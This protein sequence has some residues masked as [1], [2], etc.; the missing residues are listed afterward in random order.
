MASISFHDFIR[1]VLMAHDLQ[2]AVIGTLDR[3]RR[4]SDRRLQTLEFA[5]TSRQLACI[6]LTGQEVAL[7]K[8]LVVISIGVGTISMGFSDLGHSIDQ[9][10]HLAST[11]HVVQH[12]ISLIIR[13]LHYKFCATSCFPS[14][15]GIGLTGGVCVAVNVTCSSPSG[16]KD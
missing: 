9:P 2:S 3:H 5:G 1:S 7:F 11:T 12:R 8:D 13:G 15:I 14:P 10:I 6:G 16:G 4:N